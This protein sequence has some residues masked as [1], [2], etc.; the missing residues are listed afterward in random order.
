MV[1]AYEPFVVPGF[2]VD[3]E[4]PPLPQPESVASPA[5]RNSNA[6]ISRTAFTVLRPRRGTHSNISPANAAPPRPVRSIR[7]FSALYTPPPTNADAAV[8]D[9]VNVDGVVPVPLKFTRLGENEQPGTSVAAPLPVYAAT[10]ARVSVP[11]KL[12]LV[13]DTASVELPPAVCAIDPAVGTR[14]IVGLITVRV[15][16]WEVDPA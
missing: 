14:P 9:T 10:Q 3:P 6:A 15:T 5:A 4:D 11:L 1:R 7:R 12:V 8:L 2:D 13:T 16:T